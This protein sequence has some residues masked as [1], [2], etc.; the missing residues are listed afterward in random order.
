MVQ[1]LWKRVWQFLIKLNTQLPSDQAPA[2]LDIYPKAMTMCSYRTMYT[3]FIAALF[4]RARIWQ[5]PRYPSM[6]KQL[7][8]MW[9]VWNSI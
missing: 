5:Q 9:Y 1:S 7:N 8:Q 6:C 4:I 3:M 2:L